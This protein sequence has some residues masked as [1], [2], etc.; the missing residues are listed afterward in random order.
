MAA[1][2]IANKESAVLVL[3]QE[4]FFLGFDALYLAEVPSATKTPISYFVKKE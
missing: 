1:L 2:G 4:Q 3:G